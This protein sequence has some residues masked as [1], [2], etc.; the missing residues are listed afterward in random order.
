MRQPRSPRPLETV[1]AQLEPAARARLEHFRAAI[2]EHSRLL[3]VEH[4]LLH[5]IWEPAGFAHVLV[6]GPT[7]V[8]KSTVLKRLVKHWHEEVGSDAGPLLVMETWP[9]GPAF[10]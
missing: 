9:G 4:D 5:A 8:G 2:V 1:L 3:Q 10:D 6:V 7:G